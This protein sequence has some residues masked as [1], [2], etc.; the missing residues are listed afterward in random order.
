LRLPHT[1]DVPRE[2]FEAARVSRFMGDGQIGRWRLR[3]FSVTEAEHEAKLQEIRGTS[4]HPEEEAARSVP[5]GE[6]ICL[7]R[8]MTRH[9]RRSAFADAFGKF[10]EEAVAAQDFQDGLT[11]DELLDHAFRNDADWIPVMSDTPAEILE[12]GTA[13][14]DATGR[15]LITGLGLGCLPHALLSRDDV[16]RIDIVEIDPD[17]IA[18]TGPHLRDPRVHIH[19]A[20]ALA[21][22]EL[23]ERGTRFDYVWH[24]I[25]THVSSKNLDDA[26]AEHGISYRRLKRLCAEHLDV[27][28]TD[29][30]ALPMARRMR[31]H[32]VAERAE[33]EAFERHVRSLSLDEQVEL[34]TDQVMRDLLK[35]GDREWWPA[36]KPI[37][38][39]VQRMLDPTGG[40]ADHVRAQVSQPDFW[41]K[42]EA[43]KAAPD[44]RD[45]LDSPNAHLEAANGR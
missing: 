41:Q 8:R 17:V 16:T 19:Q 23:F 33:A 44:E 26:T 7:H 11:A 45:H 35:A 24:D 42:W 12:H 15:V 3:H 34:L 9:E 25:W 39:E 2:L 14:N 10:P 5:P 43:K 28:A 29:A 32:Q 6:Y 18:L 20:S 21:I 30:W 22:P 4:A 31:R 27:G 40:L 37:P 13:L 1:P 38:E 36:D